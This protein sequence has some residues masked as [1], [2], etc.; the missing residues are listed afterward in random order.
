MVLSFYMLPTL[1]SAYLYGR[2]HATLTAL[3]SVLMVVLLIMYGNPVC[4]R[5]RAVMD[6]PATPSGSMSSSG[7]AR[8]SSPATRWARCTSKNAP[9]A[10]AARDLSRRADDPAPLHRRRTRTPRITPIACRSTRRRIAASMR[11]QP[12][13]DRRRRAAALLHDIGKLDISRDLL[14][15]AARLTEEEYEEMQ[16]ARQQGR[17]MLEPVGGSLRRV[18]PIVL[19][20]PRQ[21]RRLGISPDARRGD[22]ARGAHHLGRRRLRLA[23]E[24]SAVSQGDVA[25]RRP[26]TSSSRGPR[27]TSIRRS[28]PPSEGV[29]PGQARSVGRTDYGRLNTN[30][31]SGSSGDPEDSLFEK[32]SPGPDLLISCLLFFRYLS[33]ISAP[34]AFN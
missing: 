13:T 14:Y 21:V 16:A 5:P 15:K 26:E 27:P 12:A 29:P 9:D 11:P 22:P 23:D 2:R 10:R 1:G 19:V 7:A 20:A 31:R 24:R 32:N 33:K 28:W 8:S 3:A 34:V 18:I 6:V 17:D 25:L 30:R 4:S